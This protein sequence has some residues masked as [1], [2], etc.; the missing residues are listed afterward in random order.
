MA[1]TT[2]QAPPHPDRSGRIASMPGSLRVSDPMEILLVEDG[3]TDSKVTIHAVRRSCVHHRLTLVRTVDEAVRFL[4]RETIFAQA[5]TP[6]LLLLDMMLIDG[7]GLQVIEAIRTLES[8]RD[9]FVAPAIVV[10]TA[11][12]DPDLRR[13][14]D[15]VGVEHFMQKPVLEST[16]TE[17]VHRHKRL[18]VHAA[19]MRGVA[20]AVPV[21]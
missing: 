11:S 4:R 5:P 14:C 10:L 2:P 16:F 17:M 7:S 15:E 19:S 12:A 1:A 20:A 8:R 3:W 13:Q 6:D 18:M 21:A 9:D